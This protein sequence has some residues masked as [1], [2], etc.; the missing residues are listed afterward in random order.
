MNVEPEGVAATAFV[1]SGAVVTVDL[2]DRIVVSFPAPTGTARTPLW[3]IRC[4]MLVQHIPVV[5]EQLFEVVLAEDE[6]S[7]FDGGFVVGERSSL[8]VAHITILAVAGD[9]SVFW[10]L[11]E[12][13]WLPRTGATEQQ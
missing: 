8:Q 11:V 3:D 1:F 5:I 2:E 13:V 7:G 4:P 12:P 6:F 10:G 9:L